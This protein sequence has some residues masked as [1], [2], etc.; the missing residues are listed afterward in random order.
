[1]PQFAGTVS[2]EYPNL[3]VG[4]GASA[5]GL[6][7]LVEI[8]DL[9]SR[10]Y[11]GTILIAT[12][13]APHATNELAS[14]LRQ[15]SRMHVSEPS[16]SDRLSC[17]H[18]Y[19]PGPNE[20]LTVHG[21]QLHL[22]VADDRFKRMQR[23]DELFFSI[24]ESAGENGVGVIL[25]GALADGIEGLKAIKAAGGVCM[26]QNPMDADFESMPKHA[27][28]A[29]DCD[30]VGSSLEIASALIELAAGRHCG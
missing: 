13:R 28:D 17:T 12:H 5:G 6:R 18:I 24:A 8:V 14:I 22:H 23:I 9:L 16:E 15:Y 3:L 2:N 1:L 11:Q 30:V 21:R 27:V 7:P 19:V 10:G 4:I 20:I 26:V 25:S 29:I